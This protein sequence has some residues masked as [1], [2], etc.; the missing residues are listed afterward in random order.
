MAEAKRK[1]KKKA[2]KKE[3]AAE[4]PPPEM[5]DIDAPAKKGAPKWVVTFSD[6]M[7]LLM[8][9]FIML[10]SMSEIDIKKFKAML[11]GLDAG[12]DI[13]RS[14]LVV[15]KA[16]Q[17]VEAQQTLRARKQT[18]A[19]TIKLMR[20]LKPLIQAKQIELL[21]REK[22][23]VIRVLQ[24]SSFKAGSEQLK[25][26]FVPVARKLRDVFAEIEGTVTVSGHTDNKPIKTRKFRSNFE[27]SS[28]RSYSVLKELLY[29]DFLTPERFVI[30]G[31]GPIQPMVSN[32][33]AKGRNTNRRVEIVIDQANLGY[34][35]RE[36]Q[37]DKDIP[38]E[39]KASPEPTKPGKK[40]RKAKKNRKKGN[41]KAGQLRWSAPG[42]V[43]LLALVRLR[44]MS[45]PATP[46]RVL[47]IDDDDDIQAL[48]R[49]AL[50]TGFVV[51]SAMDGE[52]ALDWLN[53]GTFDVILLDMN[54]P[55]MTGY[56]V[57][58]S[59]RRRRIETP[60][61]LLTAENSSA[62]IAPVLKLGVAS[63]IPKPI[64]P[65]ELGKQI[66]KALEPP[67]EKSNGAPDTAV[68][69]PELESLRLEHGEI[70]GVLH[71]RYS[72]SDKVTK[73]LTKCLHGSYPKLGDWARQYLNRTKALDAVS[74]H[75]REYFNYERYARDLFEAGSIVTARV[76]D[77][78]YVFSP[79]EVVKDAESH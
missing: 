1:T 2:G 77:T 39:D 72:D 50:K 59:A 62:A 35:D 70:V 52:E 14:A 23:I 46:I 51:T 19:D 56:D 42:C 74:P 43:D 21:V 65:K 10:L 78:Y 33:S 71:E 79:L 28:K 6:L 57:L 32:K 37:E 29:Q 61:L 40:K 4:A 49:V 48:L 12:L 20:L 73:L 76:R 63:Y 68:V 27:L 67:A 55:D 34:I 7:S 41:K 54:L 53:R 13:K 8:C 38:D 66:K 3:E 26:A 30:D 11:E 69:P 36:F 60:C 47:A 64:N 24:G 15:R 75:L 44:P 45:S 22:K 5:P 16:S 9:F 58:S 25:K 18:V 31:M 17:S